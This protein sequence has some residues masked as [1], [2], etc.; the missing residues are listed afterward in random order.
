MHSIKLNKHDKK[1]P[2]EIINY[3]QIIN[4]RISN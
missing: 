3:P 1:K 4:E 2:L